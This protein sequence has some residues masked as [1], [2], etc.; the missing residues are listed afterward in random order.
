MCVAAAVL[1]WCLWLLMLGFIGAAP[2]QA[3]NTAGEL[4]V[5]PANRSEPLEVGG[6]RPF[7]GTDRYQTAVLVAE[8]YAQERGGFGAVETIIL[9]SGETPIN[10]AAVA[11]LAAQQAAPIL[12]TRAGD[13]PSRV[14]EFIDDHAVSKVIVIGGADSV[15][16]AVLDELIGLNADMSIRRIAGDDRYGTAAAIA[17]ELDGLTNWCDTNDSVALLANGDA[18]HLGFAAAAG[19]LA[20]AMKLPILLSEH[21]WLPL[22][23]A[24]ALAD[25]RIDRVVMV[26]DTSVLSDSLIGQLLAAG[27]DR[28]ERIA[29][30]TPEAAAAAVAELLTGECDFELRAARYLVGL[31]GRDAPID[32]VV[33]GPLLGL[34]ING[35]GPIPLVYVH[36]PLASATSS[37]LRTTRTT[38]DGRKTHTDL[39]AIGGTAA[40]SDEVMNL[41]IRAATT[42][43]TL[44]A[45]ISATDG[46]SEFRVTF[47]EGLIADVGRLEAK[48][49]DLLFVNDVPAWIVEQ[50]LESPVRNGGCEALARLTVTLRNPLEAG[51][52]VEMRG[53]DEWFATNG[54]RRPLSGTSY[55]V[56]APQTV[57]P[58]VSMEIVAIEGHTDLVFAVAYD[59]DEHAGSGEPEGLTVDA[60]RV[61]ILTADDTEID[62]GAAAFVKAERFF[63]RAFYRLPLTSGGSDY[64]LRAGD[65]VDLR[66]GAIGVPQGVRSGRLRAR[67]S[68]PT[69]PF[70]VSTVRIG[71]AN[72]GVD[73]GVRT[74]M[75]NEI[76]GVS[77]RAQFTFGEDPNDDNVPGFVR[78]VG[79]WSGDADGARGN[80]WEIDSAQAAARVAETASAVS[81]TNHPAV[82]VWVDS[83]NRV[84][85]LRFIETE[86]GEPPEL[87]HGEFVGALSG[88]SAFS[89]HFEA[90]LV[91]GCGGEDVPLS[92]ADGS[93]FLGKTTLNGGLSSTSF[94]VGF[95]DYV[96]GFEGADTTVD[97]VH[98]TDAGNVTGVIGDILDA[99]IPD[100][101]Q[102]AVPPVTPADRV[103]TTTVLPY[104]RVLFRFTTADPSHT[105]GQVI[106]FRRSRIQIAQ[107]IAEG[108]DRDDPDTTDV[109][110]N[111]NPEQTLVPSS[112]RDSL[113]RQGHPAAG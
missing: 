36:N 77:R 84:V 90:E 74:T 73:D 104:D 16:G 98:P 40:V 13:L 86:D 24:E 46:A 1:A 96:S 99:L 2:A 89:R 63:G 107:G 61:R 101:G 48:L 66:G 26:G 51:D 105:I 88:N 3:A 47:S 45:R 80:G 18:E 65:L 34:G 52:I 91:D 23:A 35:S 30:S 57:T 6:V 38:V 8:R 109:N 95:T 59:T 54:D 70:G 71:P 11:G 58:K 15:S 9:V 5:D 68:T 10:G 106:N 53:T 50:D 27:V 111:Q 76:E 22:S 100:F 29:A 64:S 41:A 92:L 39:A 83:A 4:L 37:F 112:S 32:A 102:P 108:F 33:A 78:I 93:P 75:P 31:V 42:S 25:L 113:L 110:E 85:L 43:R 7:G 14:A 21:D 17:A 94:L 12:L 60:N 28:T 97:N 49:R 82:R 103:E 20:Y 87:T 67:V 44:T 55:A 62:V 81:R 69:A 79:K 56:P 19:P 72:P